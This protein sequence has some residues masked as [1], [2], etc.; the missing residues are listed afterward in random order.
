VGTQ[1]QRYALRAPLKDRGFD[2]KKPFEVGVRVNTRANI[3]VDAAQLE[4]GTEATAFEVD[5][6][7]AMDLGPEY[8]RE[9]LLGE[10]DE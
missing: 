10:R 7:R 6:Y 2:G 5:G 9:A 1:W 3:L 4:M 8:S